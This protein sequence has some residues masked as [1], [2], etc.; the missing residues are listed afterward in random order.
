MTFYTANRNDMKTITDDYLSG[1]DKAEVNQIIK[2]LKDNKYTL[3][4]KLI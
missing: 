4:W 3:N 1:V 2:Q